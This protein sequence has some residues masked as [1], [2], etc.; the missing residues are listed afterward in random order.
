MSCSFC[1][2]WALTLML[3]MCDGMIRLRVL[4]RFLWSFVSRYPDL[5]LWC[6]DLLTFVK[7]SSLKYEEGVNLLCL[8]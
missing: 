1:T 8:T 6:N 5:H 4:S 2:W 3:F 7:S